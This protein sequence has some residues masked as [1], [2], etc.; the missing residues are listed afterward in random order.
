MRRPH[1]GRVSLQEL[2]EPSKRMAALQVA[3]GVDGL[4]LATPEESRGALVELCCCSARRRGVVVHRR[5]RCPPSH[6]G[7]RLGTEVGVLR[8]A[9]AKPKNIAPGPGGMT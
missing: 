8:H 9:L 2:F 3:R 6:R 4:A 7:S 5:L 1:L